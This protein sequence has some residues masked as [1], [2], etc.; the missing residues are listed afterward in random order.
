VARSLSAAKLR[1]IIL[2]G[3]RKSAALLEIDPVCATP[4]LR[5]LPFEL[6]HPDQIKL[7]GRAERLNR[8]P[9][10]SRLAPSLQCNLTQA[11]GKAD[12]AAQ[13]FGR[14][15][16]SRSTY[17]GSRESTSAAYHRR[18]NPG[19]AAFGAPCL[20]E[21]AETRPVTIDARWTS[22]NNKHVD[23]LVALRIGTA[24]EAR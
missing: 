4:R 3:C 14:S 18:T 5:N 15:W 24:I 13:L 23:R 16:R 20:H 9:I 10:S 1:P 8:D 12:V 7:T 19:D 2:P 22:G 17:R 21:C 6:A 11:R